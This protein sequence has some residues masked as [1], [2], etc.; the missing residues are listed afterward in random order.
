MFNL[1]RDFLEKGSVSLGRVMRRP[2]VEADVVGGAGP[3]CFET[4]AVVGRRRVVG[5]E[6]GEVSVLVEV[7]G[8]EG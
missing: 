5:H 8:D 7:G 4:V 6:D 2:V 1:L 3:A